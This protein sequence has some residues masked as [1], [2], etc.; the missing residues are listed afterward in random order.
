MIPKETVSK[1]IESA[2]V[3]EVVGD[4]V[5]LKKRGAN[6]LGLCPFHNEKTPSFT[7]SPAKDIYKC[8]GCGKAGNS[9]GFIMEHEQLSFP[10]ALKYLANKYQIEIEE[11]EQTA[12]QIQEAN[13][14]ESL[15]IVTQFAAEYFQDQLHNSEK[16]RAIGLSYFKER[17]FRSESIEKFALGYNPDEWDAFTTAALQKAYKLQYL[18]EAGLTISKEQKKFDRFKGRVIF[19]IHNMSGKIIGFGGRTLNS[20]EKTAKYLNSP[21][22]DIY[23]KSK[24]L[25]GLYHS[26]K[27][28][29]EKDNCFLVEGYTDVISLHQSGIENT[30]SSSGTSLTED[31]LRLIKRYTQN[32]SIL[33]DGDTAGIKASFRGI[34][35]ILKEGMNVRIVAFPEG[36]DP[37]SYARAHSSAELEDFLHNKS[38]DF[39]RFKTDLLLKET[40]GDPIKKAE[41]IKEIINSIALI[42]DAIKRS[43]YVQECSELMDIEEQPLMSELNKVLRNQFR[44]HSKKNEEYEVEELKQISPK[45]EAEVQVLGEHQEKDII[46]LLIN[47]GNRSIQIEEPPTEVALKHDKHAK[48]NKHE[49]EVSELIIAEMLKDEISFANSNYQKIFQIY[50]DA[51]E[52]GE[53]VQERD[54]V[55]HVDPEVS[56]SCINLFSQPYLLSPNWEEKHHIETSMEY[57]NLEKTVLH[58]IHSLKLERVNKMILN[59][60]EGLKSPDNEE[61][62]TDLLKQQRNLYEAKKALASELGRIVL[63]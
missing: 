46:R 36:M 15:L 43:L 16:G 1:I 19:P 49:I 42:P 44:I 27:A 25:Y 37:D 35:M 53:K 34:D 2:R 30:V 20:N 6:L 56:Q 28:I 39:I 13:A 21:E 62:V 8:F 55:H 33:F 31:Q 40:N 29:V 4:F 9:V 11:E 22:S 59:N 32:I 18:V 23:H 7:V 51:F 58:S 17:G 5:N 41:L 50:W 26:K 47:Y 57:E 45:Q 14:R 24:V 3:E 12:E 54:L 38:Q 61:E 63:R 60:Q 10:E 48:G 52:K